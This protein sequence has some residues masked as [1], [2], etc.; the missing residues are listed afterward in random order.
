MQVVKVRELFRRVGSVDLVH[1]EGAV[2][3]WIDGLMD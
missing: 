2:G 3:R 1:V